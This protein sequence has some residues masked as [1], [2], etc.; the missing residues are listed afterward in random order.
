MINLVEGA[1]IFIYPLGLC[2]FL[3]VFIIVE[4]L[5]ALRTGKILSRKM[6]QGFV[7]GDIHDTTDDSVGGRIVHF[8]YTH[9]PD[10]ERLKA[11]ARLQIINMER[12]LFILDIVIRAAPLIGLLGTV[13]GLV[14][15]FANVSAETG[16]PDPSASMK[17]I[18][19]A[20]T[21]TLLGLAIA[22][23]ALVGGS[24]L[25]RRIDTLAAQLSVGVERLIDLAKKK[26]EEEEE[27]E[28]VYEDVDVNDDNS[29]KK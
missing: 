13:T 10:A 26:K 12:G 19:L 16:L 28:Y 20:L 5:I 2:S 9:Q 11:F 1:G 22:I 15:V 25:N 29:E 8:F 14:Q 17:G 23:P 27:W 7:E 4:R 24:Y 3:A 6:A 21:T 18:A